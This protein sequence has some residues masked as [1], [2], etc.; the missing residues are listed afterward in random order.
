MLEIEIK[1]AGNL[2]CLKSDHLSP[3]GVRRGQPFDFRSAW[4][5]TSEKHLS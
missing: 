4:R 2:V 1:R 5:P 3:P